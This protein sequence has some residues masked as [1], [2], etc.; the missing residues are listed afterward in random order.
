MKHRWLII[1][2]A[3]LVLSGLFFVIYFGLQ[4][5]P[6]QKI[7]LSRFETPTMAAKALF[8]RLDGEFKAATVAMIGV[9]KDHKE[10]MELVAAI[11]SFPQDDRVHYERILWD[12]NL[13]DPW[14]DQPTEIFSLPENREQVIQL[15]KEDLAAHRR[16][17]IISEPWQASQTMPQAS[18]HQ[19]QEGLN[20]PIT[21]LSILDF[22]RN[23]EEEKNYPIKCDVGA[24][25]TTGLGTLGCLVRIKSKMNYRKRYPSGSLVGTVDMVGLTD[26]LILLTTEK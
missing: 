13:G 23:L 12:R 3:V 11:T 8:L 10:G 6:V 9:Q 22:P 15:L 20:Q 1:F 4:P 21:S 14:I 24:S 17:L 26:Y 18:V 25:D 7:K 2:F 16:V 19:L 5:R